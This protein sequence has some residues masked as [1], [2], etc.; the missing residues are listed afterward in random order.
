[1]SVTVSAPPLNASGS[2]PQVAPPSPPPVDASN[3]PNDRAR[4]VA[5]E[6]SADDLAAVERAR[7]GEPEV[8]ATTPEGETVADPATPKPEPK[9]D[10]TPAWMKAEITKERN[11]ARAAKEEAAAARVEAEAARKQVAEALESIKA[12]TPKPPP[13]PIAEPRPARD[14]YASPEAYDAATDQWAARGAE[15]AAARARTETEAATKA[16]A[17]TAAR[18]AA[19]TAQADFVA[20]TETAWQER[21]TKAIAETPDFIEVTESDAV[22]ISEPMGF[23]IKTADNGPAMAYH[24]GKNPAEAAR[25]MALPMGLQMV[26]MGRL[27]ERLATPSRTVVS[28]APAPISPIAGTNEIATTAGREETMAEV[29]ARVSRRESAGRISVLGRRDH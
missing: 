24:L 1:M 18:T 6:A 12:L 29:A 20:R 25:I 7:R 2:D 15:L 4:G 26:E 14:D 17:E 21:R 3:D 11:A 5:G 19:E 23:A 9:P 8:A 10:N 28:R 22:A 16:A 27:A 13:E